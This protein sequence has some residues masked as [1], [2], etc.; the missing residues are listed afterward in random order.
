LRP[1][2]IQNGFYGVKK[3]D[4]ERMIEKPNYHE[5]S[6]VQLKQEA[7]NHLPKIKKYYV[8]SRVE[9]IKIL[10]M[11]EFPEDM[12]IAKKTMEELRNEIRKLDLPGINLWKLKR[13]ELVEILYPSPKQDNQNYNGGEKH[14]N[15]QKGNPNQIR[16][17][18]LKDAA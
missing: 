5:M 2:S 1:L 6:L 3:H 12:I 16:V 15:P 13:S 8:M 4:M 17:N 18:V 11:N 7:K 9:L 14:Y 10:N